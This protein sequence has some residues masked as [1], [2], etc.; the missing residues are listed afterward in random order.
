MYFLQQKEVQRSC[1]EKHRAWLDTEAGTVYKYQI[2]VVCWEHELG[3]KWNNDSIDRDHVSLAKEHITENCPLAEFLIE[4]KAENTVN[5]HWRESPK[6]RIFNN[7]DDFLIDAVMTGYLDTENAH[8]FK[9]G[10][11]NNEYDEEL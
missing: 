3:M 6:E 4:M 1:P 8:D 11:N 10:V 5:G 7:E 2:A 9:V